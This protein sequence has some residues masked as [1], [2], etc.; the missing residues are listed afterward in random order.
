MKYKYRS[1]SF[2]R[3]G[4]YLI[5]KLLGPVFISKAKMHTIAE[6]RW[7]GATDCSEDDLH[8]C[9]NLKNAI[10]AAKESLIL[11]ETNEIESFSN[12]VP[13]HGKIEKEVGAGDIFIPEQE[14][15]ATISR[16]KK[17]KTAP[18]F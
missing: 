18:P 1:S 12:M 16:P 6:W 5:L 11:S 3:R 13:E 15:K 10:V 9:K 2:K 4:V 17:Q 8:G 14:E 7:C